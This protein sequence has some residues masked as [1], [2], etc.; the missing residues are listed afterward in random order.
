MESVLTQVGIIGAGEL[1]LALGN[2]LTKAR[3]QVLYYDKDASRS[4]TGSIEDLINT[5]E[6]LIICVSSW[7]MAEVTKL[8]SKASHPNAK[9]VVI[10]CSKGVDKGFMTMDHLLKERL[11]DHYDIGVLY[12][13]MIASEINLGR[14]A[15]GILGL[16]NTKWFTTL[17]EHFASAHIILEISAD[18]HG[19][20]ICAAVKNIY[21]IGFGL[22]DGLNLGL[23]SKGKMSVLVLAELKRLLADLHADPQTAEGLA[24]IGDILATGFG[25][26][27]FNYRVG[28]TLADKLA[29]EHI[30]SEGL[31]ALNELEHTAQLKRYPVLEAIDK[32]V[33]HYAEPKTL[34]NLLSIQ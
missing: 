4:T 20:A 33:F 26:T 11:P 29:D 23:N 12:G 6:V 21:A 2:A 1:G 32:I 30:R 15:H 9:R 16:S 27:S 31:V 28:R 7:D 13:P 10:T 22:I 8:I 19:L 18:I 17:R 34:S 5:C 24:G 14:P 25:D 3:L